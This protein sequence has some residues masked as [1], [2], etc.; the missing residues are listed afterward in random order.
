MVLVVVLL[1]P[2]LKVGVLVWV[3]GVEVLGLLGLVFLGL[4][5]LERKLM[6]V[7]GKAVLKT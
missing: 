7:L 4:R 1:R 6:W 3:F 2:E 5:H